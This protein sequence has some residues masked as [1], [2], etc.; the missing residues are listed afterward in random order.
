MM[1]AFIRDL[2]LQI[3]FVSDSGEFEEGVFHGAGGTDGYSFG[4][5]SEFGAS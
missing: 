2:I 4:D 5:A 1:R 3:L